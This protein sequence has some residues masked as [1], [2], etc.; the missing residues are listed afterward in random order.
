MKTLGIAV[1]LITL[2]LVSANVFASRVES[3]VGITD[4]RLEDRAMPADAGKW[5]DINIIRASK[6]VG[7]TMV[8]QKGKT[9]GQVKDMILSRDG[10]IMLL[11]VSRSS[12]PGMGNKL[13]AIPWS[14]AQANWKDGK[15]VVNE[16]KMRLAKAPS[17]AAKDWSQFFSPDY[18]ENVTAFFG[19]K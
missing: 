2:L 17:F 4:T 18:Q 6:I 14:A 13:V 10:K 19:Q 8:N 7:R 3:K 11:I 9:L 16:T 5:K 15:V 1:G 12:G